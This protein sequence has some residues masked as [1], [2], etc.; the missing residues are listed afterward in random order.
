V[1]I[2]PITVTDIRA[3]RD[4]LSN[5]LD[6]VEPVEI[7]HKGISRLVTWSSGAISSPGAMDRYPQIREKSRPEEFEFF[8]HAPG[9]RYLIVDFVKPWNCWV[10]WT[11]T[12]SCRRREELSVDDFLK[13]AN[14]FS[15]VYARAKT[16]E[17]IRVQLEHHPLCQ[18]TFGELISEYAWHRA[19]NGLREII[20]L[21]SV[22]KYLGDRNT[23]GG[24]FLD[25]WD[26]EFFDE[27]E[28]SPS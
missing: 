3:L 16:R 4:T 23:E 14:P 8:V 28:G 24:G 10:L 27:P 1:N 25:D 19:A 21:R 11:E 26:D 15:D 7:D 5:F 12:A 9:R 2:K 13:T 22:Q 17:E 6:S 18:T 20:L